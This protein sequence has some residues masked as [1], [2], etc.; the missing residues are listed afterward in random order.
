MRFTVANVFNVCFSSI[1]KGFG[2]LLAVVLILY[3]AGLAVQAAIAGIGI[4][5]GTWPSFG[6]QLLF[7]AISCLVLAAQWYAVTEIV[8]RKAAGKPVQLGRVLANTFIHTLPTLAIG[9]A[10][11]IGALVGTV[12]FLV[13]GILFSL[14]FEVTLP[15]YVGDRTDIF[16]AFSRSREL[17][18][19]HRWGILGFRILVNVLLY[20][21]VLI[22][23]GVIAGTRVSTLASAGMT[24]AMLAA[25]AVYIVV[26]LVLVVIMPALSAALYFTLRPEKSEAETRKM[27]NVFE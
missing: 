12:L 3:F 2:A 15:A 21:T 27:A 26:T 5:T 22:L 14:M 19:G 10:W 6:L 24:P 13:P 1:G 23:A 17:T 18:R 16:G 7:M 25:I 4:F 8:L 9:V 20:V 11:L